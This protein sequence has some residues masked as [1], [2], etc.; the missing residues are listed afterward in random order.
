MYITYNNY[1]YYYC[2]II[3]II[4][5]IVVIAREMIVISEVRGHAPCLYIH[6]IIYCTTIRLV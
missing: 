1:H 4:I 2:I 3:I 5:T 6:D